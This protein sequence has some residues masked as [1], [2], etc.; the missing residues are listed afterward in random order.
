MTLVLVLTL[1]LDLD[2]TLDLTLGRVVVR[3]TNHHLKKSLQ[4]EAVEV[5]REG[6]DAWLPL[7]GN[8]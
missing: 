5:G 3:E 1:A 8:W 4:G 7:E 2:L 6:F